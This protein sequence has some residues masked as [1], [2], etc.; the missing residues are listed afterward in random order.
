MDGERQAVPLESDAALDNPLGFASL[1]G[2]EL[3]L[4]DRE[5]AGL[6]LVRHSHRVGP[7]AVRGMWELEVWGEPWLSVATC[8]L[9]GVG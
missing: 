5:P 2:H 6:S 4:L 9:R 8:A 3:W 1:A 7:N